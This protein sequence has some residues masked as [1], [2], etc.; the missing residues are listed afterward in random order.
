[1]LLRIAMITAIM[2]PGWIAARSLILANAIL[3]NAILANAILTGARRLLVAVTMVMMAAV[4]AL[5]A[6]NIS[7]RL[8]A[9]GGVMMRPSGMAATI[10]VVMPR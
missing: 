8:R 7:L 9:V 4:L 6:F 5:F 2:L 1:M 3:T 10:A